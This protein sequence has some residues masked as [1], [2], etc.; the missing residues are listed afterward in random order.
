MAWKRVQKRTENG[1]GQMSCTSECRRR[2]RCVQRNPGKLVILTLPDVIVLS[3]RGIAVASSF[4]QFAP[5][6]DG[7]IS[8]TE[9]DQPRF[10]QNTRSDG[11]AGTTSSKHLGN[12]FLSQGKV[13]GTDTVLSHQQPFRQL[14]SPSVETTAY[15]NLFCLEGQHLSGPM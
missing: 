13:I 7:H 5:I 1:A 10:L 8:A 14:L 4:F 12:E 15:S 2:T 6:Q 3:Q 9:L 11:H